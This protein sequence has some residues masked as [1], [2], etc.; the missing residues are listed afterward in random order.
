MKQQQIGRIGRV[1]YLKTHTSS[2]ESPGSGNCHSR[3]TSTGPDIRSGA[4]GIG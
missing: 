4:V 2:S 3:A 1:T